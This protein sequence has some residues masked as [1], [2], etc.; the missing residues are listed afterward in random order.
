MPLVLGAMVECPAPELLTCIIKKTM[1][2]KG[3]ES[4]GAVAGRLD[5]R[6]EGSWRNAKLA[7]E[8]YQTSGK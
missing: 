4:L 2:H 5:I 1:S 3:L 6:P 7:C 8:S